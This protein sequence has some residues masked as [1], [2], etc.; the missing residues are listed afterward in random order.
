VNALLN[1][2]RDAAMSLRSVRQAGLLLL[3]VSTGCAAAGRP[4]TF[5][6]SSTDREE[7]ASA[8][9]SNRDENP[10][11]NEHRQTAD[12]RSESRSR[13][14]RHDPATRRLI[15]MELLE[16]PAEEREEWMEYLASV[17]PEMV[18]H[19]LRARRIAA[20][21]GD[22]QAASPSVIE[23]RVRRDPL[24]EPDRSVPVVP[25]GH[26]DRESRP[27]P[28]SARRDEET[29]ASSTVPPSEPDERQEE[30]NA[31]SG[32][33]A[34]E[35]GTGLGWPRRIRSLAEWDANPLW[36][37]RSDDDA[38]APKEKPRS[39][40][41]PFGLPQILGSSSRSSAAEERE[42][43][44]NPVD[45]GRI[46]PI[47]EVVVEEQEP[48]STAGIGQLRF[49]HGTSHWEE[50]LL[51]L[52]SLMEAETSSTEP[53]GGNR[54]ER[55]AVR[56]Q[57]ALR[58]L[59][60]ISNQPERAQQAI[61]NVSREE[62]EFWTSVF[63]GLSNY[64]DEQNASDPAD[65]ATRAITQLRSAIHHLQQSARL[66]IRNLTFCEQIDDFGSYEQFDRDHFSPGQ[67]VL[68]YCE[69][70]NFKSQPTVDGFY[71]TAV[72]STVELYRGGVD[73]KLIDRNVFPTTEDLCRSLRSDYYHS[74][75]IDLPTHL[76]PGPH[77]LKLTLQDELSGK[78]A[79]ETIHLT[80]K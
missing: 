1:H 77:V 2:G 8:V 73:G 56:K 16:A 52:V 68:L 80:I 66:Q 15:E 58:M 38:T 57:V 3:L 5:G 53:E 7:R 37:N 54:S 26:T 24:Q 55:E 40:R 35:P 65:R 17:D 74:Y 48:V 76:T 34:P 14:A 78:I 79:T 22:V 45:L 63:W 61:P 25:V 4:W 59:Y 43:K 6:Q 12:N 31:N 46:R 64:L 62:Q 21:E 10:E 50:E 36:P 47:K 70:R 29:A 71:R 32:L 49:D 41:G 13:E 19:I 30:P 39:E 69:I 44:L 9:A 75:R 51:R 67:S 27:A 23:D 28:D 11:R 33:D 60:L 18:P 20:G 42:P 72:K